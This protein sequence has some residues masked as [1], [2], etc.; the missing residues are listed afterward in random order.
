MLICIA[1]DQCP[2]GVRTSEVETKLVNKNCVCMEKGHQSFSILFW[3]N[4]HRCK[5]EKPAIY[6]RLTVGTKRVE[7]STYRHVDG[8]IWNQATQ[9]VKGNSD[10]AKAINQQLTVMK[11]D[12]HRHYSHLLSLG[13]PI[14][15]ELLKNAYLG[16]GEQQVTLMQAFDL[17]NRRF[18]EKVQAGKKSSATLKK[19]EI[20][21]GKVVAF[22]KYHYKVSDKQL[23]DL[24]HSFAVDF[25]HFLTTVQ[26]MTGNTATKYLKVLKQVV[27]MAV[28]QGWLVAS[29]LA[30]YKCKYVDPE[31]ERLTMEEIMTLYNKDLHLSRLKEAR[32]VYLF[33]CF[34]GYAYQ[35]VYN[36]RPD[37]VTTGIDGEKWIIKNRVKTDS[38]ERVP[39][40]PIAL[41]IVERYKNTPYCI[42]NNCLLPVNSNQHYNAYLKEIATICGIRKHLTTHTAR[43]TFATTVTLENDV[44]IETVSQMLGHKSIRTTQIYAKIT[45]RK[46]SNNMRAL[47]NRLFGDGAALQQRSV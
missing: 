27:K 41:E 31:R 26:G 38:P 21:R 4:R 34:T 6:L 47:R 14:T 45:Q 28:E 35:D 44:P 32:D 9:C 15:A 5:N 20:T 7:L 19:L 43:H 16:I 2:R 23:N 3:L 18:A 30:G 39:L 42:Y 22:L 24:K 36:L 10:E 12:L 17:H 25:E 37:D 8:N 29:P 40:L 33:C 1:F 11:A 13:K 46:I